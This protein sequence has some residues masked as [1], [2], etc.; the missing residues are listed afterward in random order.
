M[1]CVWEYT[2]VFARQIQLVADPMSDSLI[3]V[4]V[5]ILLQGKIFLTISI[6]S[7]FSL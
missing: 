1:P 5:G 3:E 2:I 6:I 7:L 4:V